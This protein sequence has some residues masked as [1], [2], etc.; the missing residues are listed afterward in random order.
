LTLVVIVLFLQAGCGATSFTS[1]VVGTSR[2]DSQYSVNVL[3]IPAD[4]RPSDLR[5]F[6]GKTINDGKANLYLLFSYKRDERPDYSDFDYVVK[7]QTAKQSSSN[8]LMVAS[9]LW[10][11]PTLTILPIVDQDNFV[12]KGDV[13]RA[14]MENSAIGAVTIK[15]KHYSMVWFLGRADRT[16]YDLGDL[17]PI[18]LADMR[19]HP[20]VRLARLQEQGRA[21]ERKPALI[22]QGQT[23]QNPGEQ[24]TELALKLEIEGRYAEAVPYLAQAVEYYT[25]SAGPQ[26]QATGMARLNLA[27]EYLL[28]GQYAPSMTESQAAVAILA[29]TAGEQS[30]EMAL[31]YRQVGRLNFLIA[32]YADADADFQK[33]LAIRE[34]LNGDENEKRK[35]ALL[36]DRARLLIA[37]A[38]YRDA[39]A[40]L[41]KSGELAQRYEAD[42]VLAVRQA[43]AEITLKFALGEYQDAETGF[44]KNIEAAGQALGPSHPE[45]AQFLNHL[46]LLHL[47]RNRPDQAGPLLDLAL[48][49]QTQKLGENHPDVALT[50][51]N[52]AWR[53]QEAAQYAEAL[54]GFDKALALAARVLGDR[55]PF[56]G[57]T[58]DRKAR[59]LLAMGDFSHAGECA[60]SA[61][62]VIHAVLPA[63]HPLAA[64]NLAT[65][66][67]VDHKMGRYPDAETKFKDALAA[68]KNIAWTG[69]DVA[70]RHPEIAQVYHLL[71]NLYSDWGRYAEAEKLLNLALAMERGYAGERSLPVVGTLT[72]LADVNIAS[73]DYQ[74]AR[75]EL[76]QIAQIQP[77]ALRER[78]AEVA[79]TLT[80][81]AQ[82]NAA[83]G[84]YARAEINLTQAV[85][86]QREVFG[87]QSP[88]V[89]DTLTQRAQVNIAAGDYA[90]AQADLEQA[91]AIQQG[92]PDNPQAQ[93]TQQELADLYSVT[94]RSQEAEQ[95]YQTQVEQSRQRFGEQSQ[96]YAEALLN[97]GRFYSNN[98][99]FDRAGEAIARSVE[100]QQRALPPGHPAIAE[101]TR[102]LARYYEA[103]GDQAQAEQAYTRA[104]ETQ[105]KIWGADH[106]ATIATYTDLGLH[107]ASLGDWSQAEDNLT[108][109]LAAS[110]RRDQA[111]QGTSANT[112]DLQDD[113]GMVRLYED[114]LD[115]ADKLLDGA[116]QVRLKLFG[117]EHPL[118]AASLDHLGLLAMLR[119]DH[120]RARQS[121]ASALHTRQTMLGEEHPDTI[122]TRD[123][124]GALAW[125]VGDREQAK[126]QFNLAFDNIK[127]HIVK[128]LEAGFSGEGLQF[129]ALNR[130]LIHRQIAFFLSAGDAA[131]AYERVVFLKGLQFDAALANREA[132]AVLGDP[133]TRDLMVQYRA[134]VKVQSQ[135]FN[136]MVRE[137][138]QA[139]RKLF[140]ERLHGW[141]ENV[142]AVDRQ[143][144]AK[145]A[146]YV[147]N[148]Q[149]LQATA[150]EVEQAL[151]ADAGLIDVYRFAPYAPAPNSLGEEGDEV[152]V[153]FIVGKNGVS[154]STSQPAEA[155]DRLVE[156][157]YGHFQPAQAAALLAAAA[158]GAAIE[159]EYKT[160]AAKLY[161]GVLAPYRAK[162]RAGQ[163]VLVSADSALATIPYEVLVDEAGNYLVG[164]YVFGYEMSARELIRVAGRKPQGQG[165]LLVGDPSF[166]EPPPPSSNRGPLSFPRLENTGVEVNQVAPSFGADAEVLLAGAAEEARIKSRAPGRRFLYFATHGYVIARETA[167][168]SDDTGLR[169]GG[170]SPNVINGAPLAEVVANPLD[171]CGLAF[172]RANQPPAAG[173]VADDGLL[174]GFEVTG[175]NLDSVSC[176]VLSACQTG[177]GHVREAQGL[178]GLRYAFT[179]S[180][181]TT[182]LA[183]AW[184]VPDLETREL[185]QFWTPRVVA[186]EASGPTLQAAKLAEI[187]KIR[188]RYRHTHPLFWGAFTISGKVW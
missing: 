41:Q 28:A 134:A 130:P 85:D 27:H 146:R 82:A 83:I 17:Q 34:R 149:L 70:A 88:V 10:G 118:T 4:D 51:A 109:A 123:H 56:Y 172:A 165:A 5:Y 144:A 19:T 12:A 50:L 154:V 142:T 167:G 157:V 46:A 44:K 99:Q 141:S 124:L 53:D 110:A 65:L 58:L 152:Y 174:T 161:A 100:I 166:G 24:L 14:D 147:R 127:K 43:D 178:V 1:Q 59:L 95:I 7:I 92:A 148:K 77:E 119:G 98:Y 164:Q 63:N 94:G 79:S 155:V 31:Y 132:M 138:D 62:G 185:M 80:R 103:T 3:V 8:W 117:Q 54:A 156:Q 86:I 121:F 13:F 42:H 40:V 73:G 168:P 81:V 35:A 67:L 61:Q 32:H 135:F 133:T 184:S 171:L 49:I 93:Q 107:Y 16:T 39:R 9:R 112:A 177:F 151:P 129:L 104:L 113:L 33:A 128:N 48:Q 140:A 45:L 126:T 181:V 21:P 2:Y 23:R 158:D 89:A 176:A 57:E 26:S 47:K 20:R 90:Q 150:A 76:D 115:E 111:A 71:A 106:P 52:L 116:Y 170:F 66:A 38:R 84:D 188:A 136:Q 159:Q 101:A 69:D 74:Q 55:H 6:D 60:R 36:I 153:F 75:E 25:Q 78:T 143:L 169:G 29:A 186:G 11:I 22:R 179:L 105:R 187:E 125:Q 96:E 108:A 120:D 18:V 182:V 175:L 30:D 102:E 68:W 37:L 180:G 131:A 15:K 97:E 87:A 183:S 91:T 122:S 137:Q 162:L 160:A 145:S 139:R 72:E 114:D 163:L 173:S 64:T